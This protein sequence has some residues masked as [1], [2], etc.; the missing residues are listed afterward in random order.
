MLGSVRDTLS[1]DCRPR[2]LRGFTDLSEVRNVLP[3]CLSQLGAQALSHPWSGCS[4]EGGC[5]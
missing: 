2:G 1:S 4:A 5:G 3:E